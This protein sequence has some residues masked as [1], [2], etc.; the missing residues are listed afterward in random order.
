MKNKKFIFASVLVSVFLLTVG[1]TYAYFSGGITGNDVAK[2]ITVQMGNLQLF[3]DSGQ[4]IKA[5]NIEPG[6]II[7]KEFTVTNTGDFSASYSIN[8][9]D[10]INTILKD[11]L[12]Y[13]L[14][15]EA[16]ENYGS[17]EQKS[18]GE[19]EGEN[20]TALLYSQIP[21]SQAIKEDNRIETK[22]TKKY[23]LTITFNETG[24]VQ[25]YNQGKS[26][27][28]K[29]YIG[30]YQGPTI[31]K[32]TFNANGGSISTQN[33]YVTYNNT[34]K[35]LPVPTKD[36]YE[37]LGWFTDVDDGVQVIETTPVSL[38]YDHTLYAHW[39]ST[40]LTYDLVANNYSCGNASAGDPYI[41]YTGNCKILDD[42]NGNWRIKLLTSGT[43]TSTVNMNVDAFVVG[44]GGGGAF[45]SASFHGGCGGAG[46]YTKTY[47]GINIEANKG[48]YAQIGAGGVGGTSSIGTSGGQSY[49]ISTNYSANGG[50]YGCQVG[51]CNAG[52]NGGSGGGCGSY[53]AGSGAYPGAGGSNGGNGGSN[54]SWCTGGTGQGTTTR[55]F[56][57][58]NG[59]LYAGGGSGGGWRNSGLNPEW[60]NA[61]AGGAGGGGA[62]GGD[63][64]AA[65]SGTPNSGG[66]GGGG[67]PAYATNIS[68]N[69]AAGG[70][71]I[72]VMR[73]A[74]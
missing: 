41:T 48:Q 10:M 6:K 25:N 5:N 2:D 8:M 57:E 15:C 50:G 38:A 11:E 56:G 27:S 63:Y 13:T 22:I 26:F 12:V 9:V 14:S 39:K 44:G 49:F 61:V 34:Y 72:V 60:S 21:T 36:G 24:S 74:R 20:T 71:G 33:K 42:G 58:S 43:F 31:Y 73:N 46:G 19:C 30:D 45:H 37:F 68:S 59:E 53:G 55:E 3:Y 16:F 65:K 18:L 35:T 66:G 1:L 47:K 29:I 23:I 17:S 54:I 28:G 69:G 62:G 7:I 70:S 52:G 4:E 64:S 32:V 67:T 51:G 40:V